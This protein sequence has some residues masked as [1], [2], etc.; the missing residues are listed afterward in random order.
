[1]NTKETLKRQLE[2]QLAAVATQG[3][4]GHDRLVILHRGEPDAPA[5]R[6]SLFTMLEPVDRSSVF[7][8]LSDRSSDGS[9]RAEAAFWRNVALLAQ[10]TSTALLLEVEP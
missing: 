5:L 9:L 10:A 3:R 8:D 1:M 2:E 6:E 7:L 4:D